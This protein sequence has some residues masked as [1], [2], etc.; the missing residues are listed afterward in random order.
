MTFH[1]AAGGPCGGNVIRTPVSTGFW[2]KLSSVGTGVVRERVPQPEPCACPVM[3][4][5]PGQRKASLFP[6]SWCSIGG[7]GGAA[8]QLLT[9][10]VASPL[11]ASVLSR[12]WEIDT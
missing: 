7:G 3:T 4:L 5:G 8:A 9:V 2:W 11:W 1:P 10:A 6:P 12:G